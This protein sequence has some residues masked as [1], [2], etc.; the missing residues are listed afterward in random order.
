[1]LFGVRTTIGQEKVVVDILQGK[2]KAE[3]EDIYSI[4]VID[5]L[6]GYVL[7]EA[8]DEAMVRKLIYKAPHVRGLVKGAMKME[9]IEHF[10]EVKP[11]TEGIERGDTVEITSG[12]FKG[13]KARVIR[14]DA[15]KDKITVE[16]IEAV[17]PIPITVD[18]S[19]IRVVAQDPQNT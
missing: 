4:A 2:I 18:A 14:I 5:S 3:E 19:A 6:R 1:M 12:A 13:E 8:P 11:L 10:L 7:V 17:V 15:G 16:I 9:E